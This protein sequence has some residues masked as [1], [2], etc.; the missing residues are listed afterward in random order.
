[1]QPFYWALL[2]AFFWGAAPLFEK[3]GLSKIEPFP[4]LIIRC[5]GVILGLILVVIFRSQTVKEAIVAKPQAAIFIMLGGILAS[6]V[7]QMFFY[8]A[9]KFGELSKVV[10]VAAGYPIISFILGVLFL[11]EKISIAKISGVGLIVLG[12]ILLK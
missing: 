5:L 9:L 10:P 2:T 8:R 1:M 6:V 12:T 3:F 11:S 7:G 4:G